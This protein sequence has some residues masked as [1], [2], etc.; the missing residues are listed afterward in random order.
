MKLDRRDSSETVART[1]HLQNPRLGRVQEGVCGVG[2]TP[3]PGVGGA[4][5][6]YAV[7]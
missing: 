5:F 4:G 6:R 7:T 1:R 2:D 3:C